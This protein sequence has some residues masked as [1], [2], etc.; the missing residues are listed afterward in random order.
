MGG[1]VAGRAHDPAARVGTRTTQIEP[2]NRGG[3]AAATRQRPAPEHLVEA[4]CSVEDVAAGDAEF[5][6]DVERRQHLPR[7]DQRRKIWGVLGDR[8]DHLVGV[9]FAQIFDQRPVYRV[10]R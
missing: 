1:V 9:R 8:I 7:Q 4:H 10:P 3:V 2:G 5:S 6:L